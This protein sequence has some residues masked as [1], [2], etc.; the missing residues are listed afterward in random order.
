MGMTADEFKNTATL[1]VI[2]GTGGPKEYK[3]K[4]ICNT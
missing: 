3:A 1:F 2:A 4:D